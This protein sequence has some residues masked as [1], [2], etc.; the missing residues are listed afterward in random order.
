MDSIWSWGTPHQ[1]GK[2]RFDCKGGAASYN[3][4]AL[5]GYFDLQRW[6]ADC[7]PSGT[8]NSYDLAAI[9]QLACALLIDAEGNELV[10]SKWVL[11]APTGFILPGTLYGRETIPNCNN[12]FFEARGSSPFIDPQLDP[13]SFKVNR[14]FFAN[15]AWVE[16]NFPTAGTRGVLDATHGISANPET[17]AHSR[18]Q[19]SSA[20]IDP[21]WNSRSQPTAAL[22]GNL[23]NNGVAEPNGN[24]CT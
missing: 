18:Q 14:S 1:L 17:G 12:P 16:F 9:S 10:R 2:P 8:C 15:H 5:G 19:Y 24:C 13:L 6:L 23:I 4:N 11:Q 22:F 20:H 21:T 3:V 7:S